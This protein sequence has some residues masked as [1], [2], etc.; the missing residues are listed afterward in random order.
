MI[1]LAVVSN[2]YQENCC[3]YK[4]SDL[5]FILDKNYS[6]F[7]CTC[8]T[9]TVLHLGTWKCTVFVYLCACLNRVL[10]ILRILN[11]TGAILKILRI[12][13]HTTFILLL[14]V[15]VK[16]DGVPVLR[17]FRT[18]ATRTVQVLPVVALLY[19]YILKSA[20]ILVH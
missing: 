7:G 11:D 16:E 9:C 6:F 20:L 19:I 4:D 14:L 15:R 17:V 10:R 18:G 5:H 2:T 1:R 3:E 13:I 8:S 12:S